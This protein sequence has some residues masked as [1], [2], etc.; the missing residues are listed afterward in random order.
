[1]PGM[2]VKRGASLHT[3]ERLVAHLVFVELRSQPHDLAS[4]LILAASVDERPV[5]L[6]DKVGVLQKK[7]RSQVREQVR[8][9]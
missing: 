4:G 7:A 5:R 3:P 8:E 9:E 1:M 2:A 6:Q